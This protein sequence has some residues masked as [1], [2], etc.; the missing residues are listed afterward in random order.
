MARLSDPARKI[1]NDPRYE[2]WDLHCLDR[3]RTCSVVVLR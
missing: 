2:V 1:A 3:L